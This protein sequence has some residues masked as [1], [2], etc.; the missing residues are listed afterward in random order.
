MNESTKR[1]PDAESE[2]HVKVRSAVDL[3]TLMREIKVPYG[4]EDEFE[5]LFL[6]FD[7]LRKAARLRFFELVYRREMTGRFDRF[8]EGP[9]RTIGPCLS[10]K[11]HDDK[12]QYAETVDI[13]I[14][15]DGPRA[16]HLML[17]SAKA[18]FIALASHLQQRVRCSGCEGGRD[19]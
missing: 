5:R 6:E 17:S 7:E 10:W 8:Q 14:A 4:D 2:H 15:A 13:A 12:V 1:I 18:T 11:A 9:V 19:D 16:L 3:R